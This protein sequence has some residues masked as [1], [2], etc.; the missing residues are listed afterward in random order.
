MRVDPKRERIAGLI[1]SGAS[2]GERAYAAIRDLILAGRVAPGQRLVFDEIS[3]SLD[4]P[5]HAVRDA[6]KRLAAESIVV[7]IPL[8]GCAVPVF[9]ERDQR[10]VLE[11]L[12]SVEMEIVGVAAE[13]RTDEDL[14]MLRAANRA[15]EALLDASPIPPDIVPTF[16]LLSRDFHIALYECAHS[17]V[18]RTIGEHLLI[19]SEIAFL[20]G[21]HPDRGAIPSPAGPSLK[22][23]MPEA[24]VA[25]RTQHAEHL[26][27]VD[28]IAS[29]ERAVARMEIE[30]HGAT[31]V[32]LLSSLR[33]L[34]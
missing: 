18:Y 21:S 28:A 10:D 33:A 23:G 9:E 29:R 31:V 15:I 34:A 14:R 22:L 16:R 2:A 26:A 13:R 4:L 7:M 27:I 5:R 32:E 8:F 17:A 1:G 11:L 3:L 12:V 25:M 19:K 20:S 6:M 30:R 24:I